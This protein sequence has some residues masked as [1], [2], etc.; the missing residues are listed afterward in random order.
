VREKE[1]FLKREDI[2]KRYLAYIICALFLFSL[3]G[4]LLAVEKKDKKKIEKKEQ[5]Q[6]KDLTKKDP[7]ATDTKQKATEKKY[8]TFVDKN[9]N[10]IDDRK[11]NLKKKTTETQTEPKKTE[12][13]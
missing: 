5:V 13:K 2:M 10:G 12:K 9:N 1:I 11:E 3:N 7:K 8:D 6:E 4:S